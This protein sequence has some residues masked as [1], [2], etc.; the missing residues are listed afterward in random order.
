MSKRFTSHLATHKRWQLISW[1][2]CWKE[3]NVQKRYHKKKF[4]IMKHRSRA[5]I[6]GKMIEIGPPFIKKSVQNIL[7]KKLII[8]KYDI[9][10]SDKPNDGIDTLFK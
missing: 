1:S 6:C 2:F 10:T 7:K 3:Q 8:T 4:T 9:V 5:H